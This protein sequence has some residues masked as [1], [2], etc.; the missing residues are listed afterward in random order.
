MIDFL[1]SLD[2]KEVIF[3]TSILVLCSLKVTVGD[4]SFFKTIVGTPDPGHIAPE[5]VD[6]AKWN[7]HFFATFI[8]FAVIP[9]IIGKT[10]L[11][12]KSSE[13]G[14]TL[15]NWKFGLPA[16]IIL[17]LAASFPTYL[18][19]KNPE[20]L[21]FYPLT[22]LATESP[23]LFVLWS[24][25]YLPHYIGWEVFFRGYIGFESEKR[26]GIIPAI[27][28]PT[29]LTTLMH[30]GKPSGELWG[31]LV[32]GILMSLL[33]FRTRSVLWVILFHWF[34]GIL[35]SYFCGTV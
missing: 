22:T 3:W 18:S 19:S 14:V 15:G 9:F 7:Y 12:R 28:I 11:K 4:A 27:A 6:W 5:V 31:A 29:V 17:C 23:K 21:A 13:I 16:L 8:L 35:N 20:H 34:L 1:R 25:S 2:K 10:V 26:Y 33:T 30:I 32:G 24:L